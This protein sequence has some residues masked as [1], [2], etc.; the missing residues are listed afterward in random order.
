[1][2][3]RSLALSRA[4]SYVCVNKNLAVHCDRVPY[5]CPLPFLLIESFQVFTLYF[6]ES[7]HGAISNC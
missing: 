7:D 2:A 3:A 5:F 6:S 1:M 4:E